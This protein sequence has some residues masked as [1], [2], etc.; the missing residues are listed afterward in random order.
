ML[1]GPLLFFRA[2]RGR[3]LQPR[4][5]TRAVSMPDLQDAKPEEIF[6]PLSLRHTRFLTS[7]GEPSELVTGYDRDRI[8]D[9]QMKTVQFPQSLKT[10]DGGGSSGWHP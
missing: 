3:V 5:P 4:R 9:Q 2:D 8:S 10:A 6:G 1:T 7:V